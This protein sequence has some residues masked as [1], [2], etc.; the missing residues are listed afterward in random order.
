MLANYYP[1]FLVRIG[2]QIYLVETKAER[3]PKD[4]NV[5]QKRLATIDWVDKVNELKPEDRM[6]CH[7]NY[8]LLG[9]GTFYG[10]SDKG[11]STKEILDYAILT[12]A[13]VK[14]TLADLLGIKE[15]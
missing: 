15:Y 1:D 12:K 6:N 2:D 9:E 13:K 3:D 10:M 11:A 5:T 7:W 8:A 14:G 4:V